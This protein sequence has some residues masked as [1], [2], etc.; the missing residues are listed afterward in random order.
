MKVD[1]VIEEGMFDYIK[2]AANKVAQGVKSVHQAGVQQSQLANA[3]KMAA[4]WAKSFTQ[5]MQQAEKF[6]AQPEVLQQLLP[7][8]YRAVDNRYLQQAKGILGSSDG[9]KAPPARAAAEAPAAAPAQEETPPQANNKIASRQGKGALLAAQ[10]QR[11][12]AEKR[13]AELEQREMIRAASESAKTKTRGRKL[14][15]S[16]TK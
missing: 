3:Q 10:K 6:R 16:K 11:A 4:V 2:G 13:K 9:A 12:A 15:E 1:Q 5:L 14:Q 7:I 8:I